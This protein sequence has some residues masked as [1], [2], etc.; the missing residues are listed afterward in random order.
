MTSAGLD[1][2][3]YAFIGY[4]QWEDTV[5]DH[6]AIESQDATFDDEGNELTPAVEVKDA[7]SE[8]TLKAGDA[9]SF[10]YDQLNMFIARGFEARLAALEGK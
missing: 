7:W 4:D 3:R 9:F 8:V 1:W 6:P 5:I 2:T 10:R